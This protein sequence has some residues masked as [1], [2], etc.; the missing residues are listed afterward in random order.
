MLFPVVRQMPESKRVKE[1][2]T[3]RES[4]FIFLSIVILY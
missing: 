2:D 4:L 3:A 1:W